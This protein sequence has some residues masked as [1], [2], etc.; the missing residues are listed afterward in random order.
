MSAELAIRKELAQTIIRHPRRGPSDRLRDALQR[1]GEGQPLVLHHRERTWASIT[2]SGTRHTLTLMFTGTDAVAAGERFI[3]ALPEHE[4]AIPGQLVAD[5]A[6]TSVDHALLPT[7]QMEV[8]V[9]V[10]MLEDS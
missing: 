5:A 6:V 10:L 7:P 8:E 3:D 1:L 2:F 4:F 9:E